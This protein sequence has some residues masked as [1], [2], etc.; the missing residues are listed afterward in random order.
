MEVSAARQLVYEEKRR[1]WLIDHPRRS[2][3]LQSGHV[4]EKP[5]LPDPRAHFTYHLADG[6]VIIVDQHDGE[7]VPSVTNDI[8]AVLGFIAKEMR[9]AGAALGARRVV[10]RDTEG[11]WDGVAMTG[12]EFSHF[13]LMGAPSHEEALD[14][15]SRGDI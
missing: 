6:A 15:W 10:Y 2:A 4:Q 8:E 12:D 14:R 9:S 1:A 7:A 13:V 3:A 5:R 11:L